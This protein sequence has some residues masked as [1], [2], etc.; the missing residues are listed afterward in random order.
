MIMMEKPRV[1]MAD[2]HPIVLAGVSKLIEDQ[3]EVVGMVEN[4]Q[5]L[6]QAAEHLKPDLI[7]LDISMPLLDGFKAT[8]Q[9][10]RSLP[11]TKFLFLT[12]HANPRY[13]TEAFKVGAHGFLLKQS[14]VPE[15]YQA[16][17]AVLSGKY[18]VAPALTKHIIVQALHA[19]EKRGVRGSMTGLT[20]RQREVLQL[21]G[22]GKRTREIAELLR[23]SI[24]TI[25][26][27]KNCIMKELGIH[28]TIGLAHFASEQGHASGS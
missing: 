24:K 17:K 2:H 23:L 1:L 5:A 21:I 15:L 6:L 7:L 28:T 26:F 8:R 12:T 27:H 11:D 9:I 4:G 19:E 18:Y 16:I 20:S 25:E 3:Y 14:S 13:I 22:Q 10:K